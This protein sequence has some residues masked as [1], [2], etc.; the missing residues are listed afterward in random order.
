M[1][2]EKDCRRPVQEVSGLSLDPVVPYP[3]RGGKDGKSGTDPFPR[4]SPN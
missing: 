1:E 4:S 3:L 2:E